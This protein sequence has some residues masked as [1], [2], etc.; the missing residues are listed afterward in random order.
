MAT[1]ISIFDTPIRYSKEKLLAKNMIFL[2][3]LSSYKT[4]PASCISCCLIFT[5]HVHTL[6]AYAKACSAGLSAN[7]AYDAF[8]C[9]P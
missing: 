8:T 7:F 4:D 3:T 1:Y 2:T 5:I 6:Y 9:M